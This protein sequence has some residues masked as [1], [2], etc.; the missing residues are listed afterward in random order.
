[1]L[2]NS[3][4]TCAAAVSIDGKQDVV[5]CKR[6]MDLHSAEERN[7]CFCTEY[8]TGATED[9]RKEADHEAR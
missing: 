2:G 4:G 9:G 3:C 1:M 8:C 5:G 7:E 6:Y